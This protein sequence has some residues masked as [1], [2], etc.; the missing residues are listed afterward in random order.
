[1]PSNAPLSPDVLNYAAILLAGLPPPTP[2]TFLLLCSWC[3]P[4][5]ILDHLNRQYPGQ[6]SHGLCAACVDVMLAEIK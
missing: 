6:I 4:R 3:T 2:T 1:M 5:T